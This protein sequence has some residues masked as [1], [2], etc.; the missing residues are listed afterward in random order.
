MTTHELAIA[1]VPPQEWETVYDS[2]K[3]L[4]C[5]TIFPSLHKPFFASED[6]DCDLAGMEE[7]PQLCDT[8]QKLLGKIQEVS[9]MADDLR[10]YLDMHEQDENALQLLH[11]T[12]QKRKELV[13][14]FAV[15]YYPLTFQNLLESECESERRYCWSKGPLPWEGVCTDVVL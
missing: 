12:L 8:W 13:N 15:N 7:A 14:L 1:F 9:F 3:A 10:L 11:E 4:K 5:G 2:K 6:C